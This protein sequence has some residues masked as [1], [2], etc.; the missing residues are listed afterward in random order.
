MNRILLV[1]RNDQMPRVV[2]LMLGVCV[3][4]TALT[5]R[6]TLKHNEAVCPDCG[7]SGQVEFGSIDPS[8]KPW[9]ERCDEC[10][11]E[12]V[13]EIDEDGFA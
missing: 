5:S 1:G 10:R 6:V 13:V 12:G 9:T 8:V 2:E 7:G 11:G 3:D 4:G